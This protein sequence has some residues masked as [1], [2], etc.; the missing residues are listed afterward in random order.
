MAKPASG[1]SH[2]AVQ[3]ARLPECARRRPL[4]LAQRAGL[5]AMGAGDRVR[6]RTKSDTLVS[7]GTLRN[8]HHHHMMS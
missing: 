6:V 7:Y 8:M 1:S 5:P 4:R 2:A 3:P